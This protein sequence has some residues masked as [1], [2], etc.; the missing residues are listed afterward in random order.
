MHVEELRGETVIDVRELEDM[1][2]RHERS[3]RF[4]TGLH[5]GI[6][7]Q[8]ERM[9]ALHRQIDDQQGFLTRILEE[10]SE[11]PLPVTLTRQNTLRQMVREAERAFFELKCLF[12]NNLS[13]LRP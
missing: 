12:V 13:T 3:D 7:S 1:G 11:G 6:L 9:T 10:E 2:A 5:R 4:G 8:E